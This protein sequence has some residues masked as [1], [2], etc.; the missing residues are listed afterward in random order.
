[1]ISSSASLLNLSDY[2]LFRH[3]Q[4]QLCKLSNCHIKPQKANLRPESPLQS[5][6]RA[7]YFNHASAFK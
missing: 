7:Y 3:E 6:S 2:N 4:H 1:V 5:K